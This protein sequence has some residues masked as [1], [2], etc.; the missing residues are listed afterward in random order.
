[1]MQIVDQQQYSADDFEKW[2]FHPEELPSGP[3][4]FT[5]VTYLE[6]LKQT[7]NVFMKKR[8]RDSFNQNTR[9]LIS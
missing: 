1:M 7:L 9:K 2:D 5:L 6:N 8:I 3:S 4:Q